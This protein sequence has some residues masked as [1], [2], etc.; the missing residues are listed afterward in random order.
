MGA[1]AIGLGLLL[2]IALA[3][4][5]DTPKGPKVTHRVCKTFQTYLEFTLLF[6]FQRV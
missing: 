6:L 3:R 2:V 1:L 5:D 4:S